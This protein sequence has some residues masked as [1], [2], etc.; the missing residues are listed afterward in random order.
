MEA[1]GSVDT[2]A[3]ETVDRILHTARV[4][5]RGD[6]DA[7]GRAVDRHIHSLRAKLGPRGRLLET[8]VGVGYRLCAGAAVSGSSK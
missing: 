7:G 5:W 3:L 8:V 4:L 2:F 6:V 1:A